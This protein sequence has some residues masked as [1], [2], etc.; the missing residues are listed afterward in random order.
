MR[1]YNEVNMSEY[2]YSIRKTKC[3]EGKVT[4]KVTVMTLKGKSCIVS[5]FSKLVGETLKDFQM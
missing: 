1:R 2:Y 3:L 4:R 5:T